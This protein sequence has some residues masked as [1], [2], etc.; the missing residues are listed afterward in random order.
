MRHGMELMKVLTIKAIQDQRY[1]HMS[2]QW[3]YVII[4]AMSKIVVI[5]VHYLYQPTASRAVFGVNIK[6]LNW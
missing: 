6:K 1:N 5:N 4:S 3:K 2:L